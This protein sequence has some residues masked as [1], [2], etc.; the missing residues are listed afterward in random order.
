M[1]EDG[2]LKALAPVA[3]PGKNHGFTAFRHHLNT[4]HTYTHI[5]RPSRTRQCEISVGRVTD[6]LPERQRGPNDFK[7]NGALKIPIHRT[8]TLQLVNR[9]NDFHALTTVGRA[10]PLVNKLRQQTWVKMDV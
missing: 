8:C 4:R 3:S 10:M 6:M 2:R 5:S 1:G 9:T 7:D